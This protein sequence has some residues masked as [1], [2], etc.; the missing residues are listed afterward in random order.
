MSLAPM[1]ITL[2]DEAW[3][4]VDAQV[5]A[6]VDQWLVPEGA[7]VQ[8]GQAVARVILVKSSMDIA[9]PAAGLVE[10]ILVPTGETFGR[11]QP[12][13]VLKPA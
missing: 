9:A 5:Q 11:G 7:Q 10:R 13:A 12:L 4:G 8:A 6:L 1:N 3:E 2:K